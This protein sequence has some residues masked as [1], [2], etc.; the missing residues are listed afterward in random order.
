VNAVDLDPS[1]RDFRG[2]PVARVTYSP[3]AHELAAQA[4]YLPKLAAIAKAAGADTV[5]AVAGVASDR[6]PVAASEVPDTAHVMGGMR[7]GTDPATS[8]TDGTG[9]MHTVPNVVVADGGVFPTAGGHNPTLTIMATALRNA[10]E[11]AR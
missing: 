5:T 1:V 7:M 3:G 8:V 2:L 4:F 9:R 11:W 10:R 6:F